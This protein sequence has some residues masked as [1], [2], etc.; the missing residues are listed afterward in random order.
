MHSSYANVQAENFLRK[1]F[2]AE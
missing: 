1:A 2:S